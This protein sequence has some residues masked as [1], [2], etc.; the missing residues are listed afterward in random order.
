MKP[1][2]GRE[3]GS[4]ACQASI[5]A[6]YPCV[7]CL[8]QGGAYKATWQKDCGMLICIFSLGLVHKGM[9]VYALYLI[10]WVPAKVSSVC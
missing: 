10:P 3:L 1:T 5:L 4:V 2:M 9:I 8:R 7:T 6:L